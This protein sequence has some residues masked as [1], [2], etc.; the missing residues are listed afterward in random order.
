MKKYQSYPIAIEQI[1][2]K[3][4]GVGFYEGKKVLV[5]YA[6]PGQTV[7]AKLVKKRNK[8]YSAQLQQVLEPRPDEVTPFCEHFGQ[9]PNESGRGC[10][11]CKWQMLPYAA[12][13]ALKTDALRQELSALPAELIEQATLVPIIASPQERNYRNKVEFSFGDKTYISEERYRAFRANKEP[14]PT[15]EYLGF[16]APGSFGTVI[17]VNTCHL[18]SP[19]LQQVYST[20]KALI[21][22]LGGGVYRTRH[23]TGYWRHLILRE[24]VR[25]REIMV[26]LNTTDSH[27]PDWSVLTQALSVLE[28]P[29]G[30]RIRS[31]L[32]S[33]HT[34]VAQIV[35]CTPP[36]VLMGEAV[37][38]EEICGLRFEISPY[39]FFQTNTLAAEKLYNVVADLAQVT[40][41]TVIYDLYSGTGTIGM[42]LARAGA[43][44][45]YGLEDI[46]TAVEDAKR[47]AERNQIQN[48]HFKAGKVE[49]V[50]PELYAQLPPDLMVVDPPRAGLHPNAVKMLLENPVN[51][52]IYVSCNPNALARDLEMLSPVY[53]PEIVQPV[54]LFPQTAHLETVVKL[55]L[56]KAGNDH[57]SA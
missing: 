33:E 49:Q 15:G 42:I 30:Y 21:P 31:V 16:H 26:H 52:L 22:E 10:G 11:G 8:R 50:L 56:R 35:G 1:D 57:V 36:T 12:Q 53:V 46:E 17:D 39:A 9:P 34:G 7:Q 29:D 18:I 37:I 13:L 24:A 43:K 44:A 32:H 47:N 2:P 55:R 41:E 5:P 27:Q 6:V 14:L 4:K 19:A 28:L 51:Q 25:T 38:E 23:H 45:V 3:G 48:C 54:D 40:P 20:V